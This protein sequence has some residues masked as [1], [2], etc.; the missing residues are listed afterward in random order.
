MCD[1]EPW[2]SPVES[3][4]SSFLCEDEQEAGA[5]PELCGELPQ[6]KQPGH[7]LVQ[8]L[9]QGEH[10]QQAGNVQIRA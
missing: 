9:W 3:D 5:A 6:D 10:P 8:H 2:E 1:S 7:R 4:S